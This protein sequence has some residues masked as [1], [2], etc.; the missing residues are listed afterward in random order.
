MANGNGHSRQVPWTYENILVAARDYMDHGLEPLYFDGDKKGPEG[1]AGW[2][3]WR[4]TKVDLP[5]YFNNGHN[6]GLFTRGSTTDV[7]LDWPEARAIAPYYLPETGMKHGRDGSP[8]SHWW[9]ICDPAPGYTKYAIFLPDPLTGKKRES[10]ILEIRNDGGHQ[11]MVPPSRHPTTGEILH[12]YT[13]NLAPE[14]VGPEELKRLCGI[15]AAGALICRVWPGNG[16]RQELAMALAGGLLHDGWEVLEIERFF[17]IV[18]GHA[19]FDSDIDEIKKR[20]DLAKRTAERLDKKEPVRGWKFLAE[21]GENGGGLG[22]VVVK[23]IRR[24]LGLE[25]R[26]DRPTIVFTNRE[27]E[28]VL[29]DT[30][31]ALLE[32][33]DPPELMIRG[34]RLVR[35]DHD[36]YGD[37]FSE[38]LSEDMI[39]LLLLSNIT[40][41]RVAKDGDKIPSLPPAFL[42]RVLKSIRIADQ[43]FPVLSDIVNAPIMRPDGSMLM[44]PG[45]DKSTKLYYVASRPLE[46]P[47]V[48]THPTQHDIS[49]A[50]QLL[51]EVVCDFPFVGDASRANALGAM[52]T[53][54]MRP[55]IEGPIPMGIFNKP[56][57]GTGGSLLAE[58]VSLIAT[59]TLP[60]MLSQPTEEAEWRKLLFSLAI[61]SRGISV[62]DNIASTLKSPSLAKFITEGFAKDRL[63]STNKSPK[64]PHK[65]MLIGSGNNVKVEG[66]MPRRVYWVQ[67]NAYSPHPEF[68]SGFKHPELKK[69]VVENRG[70]I[71]S[72]IYTLA[73]AWINAGRPSPK[74]SVPTLGSF[75]GWFNTIGGILFNAGETNF[76]GNA[77]EMRDEADI[78]HAQWNTFIEVW[79]KRHGER[80]VTVA[81]LL[82]T[83]DI[84][85][86]ESVP[87]E[88]SEAVGNDAFNVRLG[89]ALA[90]KAGVTFSCGVVLESLDTKRRGSRRWRLRKIS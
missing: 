12:W 82:N 44:K 48:P 53:A 15:V 59:G 68:R 40:Y 67:M 13:P 75:E 77:M 74:L 26:V 88:V 1:Y 87:D 85:F 69:W 31:G 36:E 83:T 6:I 52:I 8:E 32:V 10:C 23:A 2:T 30:V 3:E 65:T 11:T 19:E 89:S 18:L 9:Y 34:G 17:G 5:K 35:V 39:E 43:K 25:G 64:A 62:F 22:W 81:E 80:V 78:S 71:L 37:P 56:L 58:V 47:E 54:V 66:D 38:M 28:D 27:P 90:G 16:M 76:L 4:F 61:E 50:V 86:L 55:T 73:R 46:M 57:Q 21:G 72:A 45:Y 49:G 42:T 63:L 51:N 7:D 79:F 14:K 20:V 70:G 84:E 60:G 29:R 41:Y 33:N 24:F